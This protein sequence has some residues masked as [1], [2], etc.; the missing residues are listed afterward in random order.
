MQ[1]SHPWTLHMIPG[2]YQDDLIEKGNKWRDSTLYSIGRSMCNMMGTV[3]H[4]SGAQG[5]PREICRTNEMSLAVQREVLQGGTRLGANS[6]VAG[7]PAGP[8]GPGPV[9]SKF[10]S[11]PD[12]MDKAKVQYP[13]AR[14]H[15][16]DSNDQVYAR[17]L[18]ILNQEVVNESDTQWR[19]LDQSWQR[20]SAC[21]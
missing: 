4:P 17:H 3:V 8:P 5:D 10:G 18:Q 1:K 15:T 2:R 21:S 16:H 14:G 7:Y 11:G 20:P 9:D 6:E 19:V 12:G 13:V